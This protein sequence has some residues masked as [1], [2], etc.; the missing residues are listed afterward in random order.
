MPRKPRITEPGF[1]H[2][3]N[4][5]V[6]RRNIYLETEDYDN[7]L[8]ILKK[9]FEQYGII[10]HT[11][12]LMTNHYH[13]LLETK[14]HNISDAMKKLNSFYSIY[15][16]KKYNRSGH[17]WQGRFASYYLY[18]DV[19][20]WYVAKYIERNPIKANMI[21]K[22][23][24][25]KYQSFFQWKF[26]NKYFELLK[27]SKIFDMTLNEYED[28]IS[29]DIQD[30]FLEKIYMSPKYIK[31]DGKMKI[32]YKRLET[33]FEADDDANRNDNIKKAY[34]YG[35]TNAEIADCLNLSFNTIKNI[36]TQ[37]YENL[38]LGST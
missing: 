15:F 35:Y 20:F 11:Y 14:E 8:D 3:I 10:L 17:L 29:S 36:I 4:R 22:V 24:H 34:E 38:K 7:F 16:N 13:L 28:F 27:N 21:K 19:H 2:V 18:D 9:V 26:K 37:P 6:E 25:Y 1:Y 5:G 33:F 31:K 32:L 12:C 30:E 23:D